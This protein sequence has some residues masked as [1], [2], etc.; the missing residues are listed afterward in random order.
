MARRELLERMRAQ[1]GA[2]D[3]AVLHAWE[4]QV[5]LEKRALD[6]TVAAHR[7][8]VQRMLA[9]GEGPNLS[10][11]QRMM[12]AWFPPLRTAIA[13]EQ[14]MVRRCLHRW[15]QHTGQGSAV[16]RACAT[17]QVALCH[18]EMGSRVGKRA[19]GPFMLLLDPEQMAVLTMHV[20][21]ARLLRARDPDRSYVPERIPGGV[22]TE[23][24]QGKLTDIAY[25]VGKVPLLFSAE[26]VI[27]KDSGLRCA[28]SLP[29]VRACR[30]CRSR[31][32]WSSCT[33]AWRRR[34]RCAPPRSR[35]GRASWRL[36]APCWSCARG[37]RPSLAGQSCCRMRARRG[38]TCAPPMT[39]CR[40]M[41]ATGSRCVLAQACS[42]H[43]APCTS[44]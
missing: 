40:R 37:P 35:R 29:G 4:R 5:E 30:R 1:A 27:C 3:D 36:P 24:G 23:A 22:I 8:S 18:E 17:L 33:R 43:L 31:W 25:D 10:A 32:C 9:R 41:C 28:L 19:Y 13:A 20:V 14:R 2:E 39:R 42:L 16:I 44:P 12:A 34:L 38:G 26:P 7:E 21:L 6:S 15:P 11:A